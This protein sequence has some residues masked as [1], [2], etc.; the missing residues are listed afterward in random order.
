LEVLTALLVRPNINPETGGR[1]LVQPQYKKK[2]RVRIV[3][4]KSSQK[5]EY[6]NE[7]G[8]IVDTFFAAKWGQ[9]EDYLSHSPGDYYMY[10]V[11]L[12][13]DNSIATVVEEELEPVV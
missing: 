2:Q 13:K 8:I 9:T 10:K 5:K 11:R 7:T 1:N 4:V 3:S 12:D 6:L